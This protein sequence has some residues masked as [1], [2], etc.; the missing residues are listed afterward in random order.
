MNLH[1]KASI[2]GASLLIAGALVLVPVLPA[3][4]ASS[5]LTVCASPA[6][7][8]TTIQSAVDAATDGDTIDVCAG[9]FDESVTITKNIT[10]RGAQHGIDARSG[11]TNPAAET[12]ISAANTPLRYSGAGVTSATVDGFTLQT[13]SDHASVIGAVE[14]NADGY[15]WTNNIVDAHNGYGFNFRSTGAAPT[16]IN[17]NRFTKAGGDEGAVA[18]TSVP[19]GE[20][21]GDVHIVDNAFVANGVGI[22][23]I[24]P[25][26]TDGLTITGNTAT[27]GGN[28]L[29]SAATGGPTLVSNNTITNAGAS[30]IFLSGNNDGMTI[31]GNTIT[32]GAATG[33]RLS[34]DVVGTTKNVV[35][36]GN[37]IVDRGYG[38]RITSASATGLSIT[39]NK[40]SGSS[41]NGIRIEAAGSITGSG[42][43]IT[44][45]ASGFAPCLDDTASK[46][47][48]ALQTFA[49]PPASGGGSSDGGTTDAGDPAAPASTQGAAAVAGSAPGALAETGFEGAP[50]AVLGALV[51]ILGAA[52]VLTG[53]RRA[54]A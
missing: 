38:I 13:T 12:V 26:L 33:V 30:A 29:V 11:R 5:T 7:T 41:S 19:D 34:S 28:F 31:R 24:G 10:L 32:G 45:T 23:I 27:D 44:G 39:G 21:V 22:N 6:A 52:L 49:A 18:V 25:G 54:R 2:G 16:T 47:C 43:T 53:R 37:T 8:Y 48:P 15:T 40:I 1:A 35:I 17:H 51:A 3:S 46:V 9:V 42:N 14:A 36:D 50:V 4:A 20:T